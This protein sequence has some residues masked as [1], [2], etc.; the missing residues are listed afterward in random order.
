[1][2]LGRLEISGGAMLAAALLLYLDGSGV[3]GWALLACTFHELGHWW[4]I[5]ALGGRVTCLRLTCVGAE[6]RS[7]MARP[8]PPLRMVL[9]ALAGPGMNLLLAL[10]GI[11]LAR[12]GVGERLYLFAGLNLGLAVFNLLP[13]SWL[14]GGRVLESL[15]TWQGREELGR[16]VTDLCAFLVAALLLAGGMLLF[17]QSGGRN[18]TVLAAGVWMTGAVWRESGTGKR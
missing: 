16:R 8:L 13:A 5:H 6:L 2:T 15:L 17:W 4:A 14:D 18:F 7:S 1:M 3:W 9:A 12:R 11:A 10:A